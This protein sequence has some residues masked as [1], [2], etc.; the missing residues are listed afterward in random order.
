MIQPRNDYVLIEELVQETSAGGIILSKPSGDEQPD[1][2][3]ATVLQIGPQVIDIQVGDRVVVGMNMGID[4][5]R[6]G[7]QFVR[8]MYVI[9]ILSEDD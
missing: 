7:K 6:S 8:E 3:E 5:E 1:C 2:Y 9:G 4:H